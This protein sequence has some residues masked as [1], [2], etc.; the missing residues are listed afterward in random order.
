MKAREIIDYIEE[1]SPISLAEQWDNVGLLVGS[2]EKKVGKVLLALDATDEVI[3]Q[4]ITQ[5]CDMLITHH[6]LIFSGMKRVTDEDFIGRRILK[7]IS[8]DIAY[9]AMHTNCDVA[10]MNDEAASRIQLQAEDVL[11]EVTKDSEGEVMGIGKVGRIP[12]AM[13][14]RELAQLVKEQ[15]SIDH[16]RVTGDLEEIVQRVA[17]STGS[18]KSMTKYA[19][20]KGAQVMISGDMDHHTVIDALAQG[21]QVIDAGHFGT[22]RFMV[23]YVHQYLQRGLGEQLTIL[24]AIEKAPFTIV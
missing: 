11:E 17:I 14:I 13:T 15:F 21:M 5:E 20:A 6:P 4:A 2:K 22:E 12:K 23:D 19:V 3:E 10:I 1:K 24:D 7:L 8:H 9:Y 18:G 16:V